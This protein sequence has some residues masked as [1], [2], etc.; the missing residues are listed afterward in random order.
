MPRE[1]KSV[2]ALVSIALVTST[3]L[4]LAA[5]GLYTYLSS[6]ASLWSVL[7]NTV[8]ASAD[9]SSRLPFRSA[10]IDRTQIHWVIES[11]MREP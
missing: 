9:R 1:P 11:T 6:R 3:T 5:W 10:S 4:F 8:T 7:R 2:A